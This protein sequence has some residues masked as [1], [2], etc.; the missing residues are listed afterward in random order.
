MLFERSEWPFH[1]SAWRNPWPGRDD[2]LPTSSGLSIIELV[3][4]EFKNDI[5]SVYNM[6]FPTPELKL[7]RYRSLVGT[8]PAKN[9]Q[10]K[11]L[12]LF[13]NQK[14]AELGDTAVAIEDA[15]GKTPEELAKLIEKG[16]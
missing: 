6:L 16:D 8:K 5:I 15:E 13:L 10:D 2:L 11:V 14:Q 3:E 1:P 12:D 7:E 4:L 9:T